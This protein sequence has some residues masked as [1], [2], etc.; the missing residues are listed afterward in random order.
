MTNTLLHMWSRF[1]EK[2]IAEHEFYMEQANKRLL[3]QF[4]NIEN[5]AKKYAEEWLEKAS[6]HFDPDRHD[7]SSFYE[8]AH[9][10]SV[11]FYQMLDDMRNRTR[12]SVIAG[13]FHE[14]DK[15]LRDWMTREINH[16]HRGD[17]AKKALW[18]AN[19]LDIADL[20]EGL[21]WKIKSQD[22]YASLDRCRLVVNAYKHG[23]GAAFQKIKTQ[24]PEFIS[25]GMR[26]GL[27]IDYAAHDD[28]VIEDKHIA[29]FSEAIIKFWKDVPEHIFDNG[30][31]GVPA[32]FEKALKKDRDQTIK[33]KA[34]KA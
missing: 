22:Y 16:W 30:K 19:F 18:G 34:A 5:E 27:F 7:P 21:G 15:Q 1:K 32:W 23:D 3:S 10:E 6:H 13:L 31:I 28:L 4:S 29:E 26:D 33:Q 9:E 24:Y 11:E 17:E 2:L 25:D 14:W 20:L 8:Q 12:L